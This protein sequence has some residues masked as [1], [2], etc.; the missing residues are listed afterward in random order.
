MYQVG[1]YLVYGMEGV[2]RVAAIGYPKLSGARRDQ[3]YYTL[4]P[5][6]KNDSIY[7]PVDT[8][9]YIRPPLSGAQAQAL[10]DGFPDRPVCHDLPADARMLAPYY[11]DI[12][13]SHDCGRLAQLY[14]TIYC[15]QQALSSSRRSLSVTDM[16]YLKLAEN[17][18][19]GEISFV[20]GVPFD[21]VV[22]SVRQRLDAEAPGS[23]PAP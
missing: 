19:F 15:K 21:D 5:C 16:R 14:K 23:T 2:C 11:Q 17:L 7:T 9:V 3:L 20:L 18:L 22:R 4:T 6:G 1:D 12:I 10:L 13:A 8:Q